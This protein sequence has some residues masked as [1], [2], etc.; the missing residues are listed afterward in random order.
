MLHCYCQW[1]NVNDKKNS[2]R[3]ILLKAKTWPLVTTGHGWVTNGDYCKI[4][5]R[6]E[7]Y[8]T[9]GSSTASGA[10]TLSAPVHFLAA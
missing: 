4:R 6:M 3:K 2:N 10:L 8:H 1:K 7:Q 9:V 5:L